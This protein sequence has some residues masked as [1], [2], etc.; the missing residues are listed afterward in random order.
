MIQRLLNSLWLRGSLTKLILR[1]AMGESLVGLM[2]AAHALEI[3]VAQGRRNSALITG[4]VQVWRRQQKTSLRILLCT[5]EPTLDRK[6]P[7]HKSMTFLASSSKWNQTESH[8]S[9][10]T[11]SLTFQN[12]CENFFKSS[13]WPWFIKKSKSIRLELLKNHL[14]PQK[15]TR[16]STRQMRLSLSY[17]STH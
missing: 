16:L 2:E 9:C 10:S 1:I 8:S 17:S 11:M 5:V 4:E 7:T 6:T 13:T 3:Q 12:S 15:P 14:V